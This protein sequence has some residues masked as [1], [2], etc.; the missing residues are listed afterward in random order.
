MEFLIFLLINMLILMLLDC[1]L[2]FYGSFYFLLGELLY[3]PTLAKLGFK[4]IAYGCAGDF[5]LHRNWLEEN[6]CLDCDC[7]NC[8]FW[9]CGGWH[10]KDDK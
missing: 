8:K 3:S 6:C 5:G 4:M 1:I 2:V 9:T 7:S 10:K